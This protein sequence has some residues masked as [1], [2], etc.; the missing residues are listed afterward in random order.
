MRKVKSGTLSSTS[1]SGAANGS[2]VRFAE[3][4]PCANYLSDI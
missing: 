3:F 2:T 4:M 1:N